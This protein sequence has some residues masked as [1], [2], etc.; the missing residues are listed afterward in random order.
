MAKSPNSRLD[1][2]APPSY[3]DDH[4]DITAAFSQL[5]LS[6]DSSFPSKDQCIAHLKLLEAIYLLKEDVVSRDGLYGIQ[7]T[8]ISSGI[9]DDEAAKILERVREKKWQVFVCKAVER[10]QCWFK[11]QFQPAAR[12][13]TIDDMV[14]PTYGQLTKLARPL[15]PAANRL[16]P[17]GMSPV[18]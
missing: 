11:N 4:I 15:Q 16:P 3:G 9:V 1:N 14:K 10:F 18:M 7:E 13:C 8:F 6:Q 2:A 12:M 5:N 17:L